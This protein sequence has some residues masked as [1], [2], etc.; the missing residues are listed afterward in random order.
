M[1]DIKKKLGQL[2]YE[3]A[4]IKNDDPTKMTG[5][6]IRLEELD[7]LVDKLYPIYN[8]R[9]QKELLLQAYKDGFDSA[10]ECL[11]GANKVVQEKSLIIEPNSEE[12]K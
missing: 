2:M 12:V 4:L 8:I 9:Y 10:T 11:I 1:E 6:I 3:V 7:N 5:V